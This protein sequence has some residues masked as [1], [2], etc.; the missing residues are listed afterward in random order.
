[1]K[2]E[3]KMTEAQF[4]EIVQVNKDGGTPVMLIGGVDIGESVQSIVN[5]WW[6]T[7][8]KKMRFDPETVEGSS[9]GKLYFLATPL[10]PE[11]SAAEKSIDSYDTL[12]KIVKQL[13]FCKYTSIGGSL[14]SNSAFIAL[15][16]M[17]NK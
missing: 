3:F 7:L 5:R 10:P 14:E 9:R 16:R 12:K 17:A 15:K 2:Q 4:A 8:G 6:N 1:M 11:K 13:E